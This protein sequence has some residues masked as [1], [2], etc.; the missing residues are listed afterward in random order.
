MLSVGGLTGCGDDDGMGGADAGGEDSGGGV[1]C[2]DNAE[3][4]DGVFCNG[5][6]RCQPNAAGADRSGCVSG[7]APRCDDG[8]ACTTDMCSHPQNR[9]LFVPADNDGDG[10]AAATCLGPDGEALGDDCDDGDGYRFPGNLEVCSGENPAHDED[11]DADTFGARDLD[12]D[13][14]Q[15]AVC[16][17]VDDNN[18]SHCGSDCDDTSARVRDGYPELC[19]GVDND[20]DNLE[21]DATIDV[22]WYVDADGDGYGDP[23]SDMVLSCAIVTDRS[24]VA[25]DCDDTRAARHPAALEICNQVDDDCDGRTDEGDACSCGSPGLTQPCVC[26]DNR[27]GFRQCLSDGHWDTC[28][29][30]ECVDGAVDCLASLIPRACVGGRWV[31]LSACAGV[32]PLCVAGECVCIDGTTACSA[33]PD[34][35]PPFVQALLP[36]DGISSQPVDIAVSAVLSETIDPASVDATSFRLLDIEGL[37]VPAMRYTQGNTITLVPNAALEPGRMYRA[38]LSGITDLADNALPQAQS[39]SFIT[40]LDV[41]STLLSTDQIGEPVVLHVWPNGRA[42][43][44]HHMS[45]NPQGQELIELDG[46]NHSVL[47]RVTTGGVCDAPCLAAGARYAYAPSRALTLITVQAVIWQGPAINMLSNIGNATSGDRVFVYANDNLVVS[48]SQGSLPLFQMVING[49]TSSSSMG[50]TSNTPRRDPLISANTDGDVLTAVIVES[51]QDVW[52]IGRAHNALPGSGTS[53]TPAYAIDSAAAA[54]H[55]SGEGL[56]AWVGTYTVQVGGLG[57][58]IHD[59]I[60]FARVSSTG[61]VGTEVQIPATD[62]DTPIDHLQVVSAGDTFWIVY[63]RDNHVMAL[64]ITATTEGTPLDISAAPRLAGTIEQVIASCETDGTL[65]V[66]WIDAA[67]GFDVDDA[68]SARRRLPDGTLSPIDT[69]YVGANLDYLRSGTFGA[70][71]ALT[72]VTERDSSSDPG[73]YAIRH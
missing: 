13:G 41:P 53:L 9:C 2:V 48:S 46:D 51:A 14:A 10:H 61:V 8:I 30:R 7:A 1:R 64:P 20:C 44:S 34:R 12:G 37:S 71:T 52:R 3:C 43:V 57:S 66:A 69:L 27:G 22:P 72:I 58:F 32:T 67:L 17:N 60:S 6:E 54:L 4:D 65:Y 73:I 23:A 18:A 24:V 68:V 29:C 62:D 5:I 70:R 47:H 50:I 45:D 36:G 16:C 28:D 21:D 49:T 35:V 33:L 42:L 56:V 59:Q 63:R 39:W 25:T 38:E 31:A 55:P 40:E 26:G 15:D 11:C 19:D